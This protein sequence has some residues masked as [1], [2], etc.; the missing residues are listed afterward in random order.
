MMGAK[1]CGTASWVIED[2]LKGSPEFEKKYKE[3]LME[4][5]KFVGAACN[6]ADV[7]AFQFL[8]HYTALI[9]QSGYEVL[10][11]SLDDINKSKDFK[12]FLKKAGIGKKLR[13]G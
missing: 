11:E 10:K 4:L 13:V 8:I 12:D 2:K 7:E 5:T 1:A 6:T 3:V 9:F